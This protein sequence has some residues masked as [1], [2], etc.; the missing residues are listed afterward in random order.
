MRILNTLV[1]GVIIITM[2]SCG[3]GAARVMSTNQANIDL[4]PLKTTKLK[5]KD[6][7]RWS[8]LDLDRDT[9]PGMSVDKAYSELLKGK[10]ANKIIVA[11]VDSG[12]DIEH[13]DLK[14]VIWKNPKEIAGNK[15]DDD[16]NGYIDDING[17]NFLGNADNEQLEMTR[18]AKKGNDGSTEYQNAVAELEKRKAEM[19]PQKEQVDVILGSDLA[20]KK[21]LKKDNYTVAE[22]KAIKTTDPALLQAQNVIIQ[23]LSNFENKKEFDKEIGKYKEQVYDQLNYNLNTEFDGRKEVGDNPNDINDKKYGSNNVIGPKKESGRHGTHV[24]GIIAGIRGNGKGGDGIASNNVQIMCL[25]AVPN[26]DEYDKDIA[27]AIRYAADNGAKVING[28][29]GKGFSPNRQ[30][31]YEAIKYAA[32]KDV[33]FVHA[34]GN[35][36]QDIDVNPNFPN[37]AE[38]ASP[39]YADNVLTVG[40]LNFEYGASIMADFSNYGKVNVDVFAPGVKIYSSTPKNTYEYLGGTSMASPNTAGVAALIRAYY[41][42]LSA[43]QV[44]HIIMDSGTAL[45]NA[46]NLAGSNGQQA[47]FSAI[48]KSGKIVN[49]YNALIMAEKLSVKN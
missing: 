48:S 28:S 18:I 9:V 41:P 34:A 8:H 45:T 4:R 6:L 31:V 27:L 46:F 23:V 17:W 42:N 1:S 49:A 36:A 33:L 37:D 20:M 29:F 10:K 12:I 25:R 5:D 39:E 3:G 15:K 47:T 16:N 43:S 2:S 19:A 7:Q 21:Q 38:G 14:T 26:G 11:I 44:K 32:S 30:W 35:D 13:E 24:A 40:A 22:V